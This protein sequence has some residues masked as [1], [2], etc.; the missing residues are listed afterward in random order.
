M[1]V[2][3]QLSALGSSSLHCPLLHFDPFHHAAL[4]CP[5]TRLCC[6]LNQMDAASD[7]EEAASDGEEAASDGEGAEE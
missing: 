5:C 2:R 7:G 1:Q 4:F 6:Q 3:L